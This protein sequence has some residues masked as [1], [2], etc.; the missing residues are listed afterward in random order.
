M[1]TYD[2]KSKLEEEYTV[3]GFWETYW[4]YLKTMKKALKQAN[5]NKTPFSKIELQALSGIHKHF[6]KDIKNNP[7]DSE[8][9]TTAPTS[10]APHGFLIELNALIN[11]RERK[12][13]FF[14]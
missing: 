7:T 2:K 3:T 13:L 1:Y 9:Y 14:Y 8:I 6:S 11:A 4:Y 10:V 5:N 12:V